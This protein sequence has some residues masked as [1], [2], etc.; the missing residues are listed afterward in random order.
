MKKSEDAREMLVSGNIVSIMLT[1]YPWNGC[2][3]SI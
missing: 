3:W 2:N 1:L